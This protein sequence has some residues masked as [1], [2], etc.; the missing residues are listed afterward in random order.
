LVIVTQ[1]ITHVF[2]DA[3]VRAGIAF[4]ALAPVAASL[5][6]PGTRTIAVP[7]GPPISPQGA[8]RGETECSILGSAVVK[9]CIIAHA[10]TFTRSPPVLVPTAVSS[11]LLRILVAPGDVSLTM[12]AGSLICVVVASAVTRTFARMA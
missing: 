1:T 8:A 11:R 3:V 9:Q 4:G 2:A 6:S 5:P 10:Q 12:G 7:D